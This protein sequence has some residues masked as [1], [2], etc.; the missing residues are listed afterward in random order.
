MHIEPT[1]HENGLTTTVYT[2]EGDFDVSDD[3]ITWN[4]RVSRGQGPPSVIT[5]TIPVSSPAVAALA[6]KVV[7]D[8]IVQTIDTDGALER[9]RQLLRAREPL[10]DVACARACEPRIDLR[11]QRR[12]RF[13]RS[14]N[15]AV[16]DRD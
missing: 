10:R 16:A 3:A 13:G 15:R 12:V 14:R 6:D 9:R 5:G 2:Y 4:A 8:A 11:R 1:T 7:R